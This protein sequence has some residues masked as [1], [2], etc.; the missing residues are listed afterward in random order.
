MRPRD[1]PNIAL[2][3]IPLTA[4]RAFEVAG[5]HCH[6]R[7]GAEELHISHSAL[8]RHVTQLEARLGVSL[9]R[10]ERNRLILTPAGQRLLGSVQAAF[11]EL[12]R[13][14]HYLNPQQ[15]AGEVVI[16][17][18]ATITMNWLL[19]VLA[20][21]HKQYPE[22]TL[23]ITTIEPLQLSFDREFDIALCLGR[24]DERQRQVIKLYD[25]NYV[26][27]GSP[28][29]LEQAQLRGPESLLAKPLLHDRLQQWPDWFAAQ[30]VDYRLAQRHIY[31]DYAY[32]AIEAARQG[33]G[34]V[35]A[36]IVEVRE[37][38]RQGRLVPAIDTDYKIGQSVY[39][40]VDN[41][42]RLA[43]R[44]QL[45]LS[46]IIDNLKLSGARLEEGISENFSGFEGRK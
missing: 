23:N 6:I 39:L 4:L 27:V 24:P 44:T 30:D 7:R 16:A 10:R 20:K 22:V 41:T 5:R 21:M 46:S 31:F 43:Y 13:G 40:V 37:D 38:I 32:Q 15:V 18:T 8:S 12:N 36:D 3:Q 42:E 11:A 33:M 14:L 35:L 25:E 1:V 34:L 45:V 2:Q 26:P 17:S 29:L 28:F 19:P 9:F